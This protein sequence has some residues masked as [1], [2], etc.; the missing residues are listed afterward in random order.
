MR[1]SVKRKA[2]QTATQKQQT[3][4][5]VVR[6][7]IFLIFDNTKTLKKHLS[8]FVFLFHIRSLVFGATLS[9]GV[10]CIVKNVKRLL[11]FLLCVSCQS[12]KL[13]QCV[14]ESLW[15]NV[16]S[17]HPLLIWMQSDTT[18]AEFA[19]QRENCYQVNTINVHTGRRRK[20]GSCLNYS[21][22]NALDV[23]WP[24]L[25]TPRGAGFFCLCVPFPVLRWK[26]CS[27]TAQ[28]RSWFPELAR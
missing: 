21:S 20:E 4:V 28:V 25:R 26:V 27:P 10:S 24:T 23:S 6:S 16:N 14:P 7:K 17:T 18:M 8:F 1:V 15:R 19:Q 13:E 11:V 5:R 3:P 9:P 12:S 22:L 2:Q